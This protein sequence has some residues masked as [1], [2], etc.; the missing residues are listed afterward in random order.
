[1]N[2]VKTLLPEWF[3]VLLRPIYHWLLSCI[4]AFFY[5]RPSRKLV[6]IGVTGT[7]GKT[8]VVEFVSQILRSSGIKTAS[9]SSVY[10]RVGD[11]VQKNEFKM[12]MPGR[13]F[14]QKFLRRAMDEGATHAVLEITSE[15]VKQFRHKNIDWDILALTNITPEHIESH[16]SFENYRKA[17]EKVFAELSK[18]FRK[19][20]IPKMIIVNGDDPESQNFLKYD[21]DKKI[22]YSKKDAPQDTKLPGEFNLYNL[23][24]AIKVAEALGVDQEKIRQAVGKIE[25]VPGRMEFV[26]RETFSVVIDYAHT[27]DALRKVYETL[28]GANK[29]LICVL[30]SAGGG[31]DKWKRK[32]MGKIASEFC[33]QIIITNEDPYDEN[34]AGIIDEVALGAEESARVSPEK[35]A[36]T[37]ITKILDRK[38]A[39]NRAIQN[40]RPGDVVIIT[41]KGVEPWIM[42]PAGQKIPWDDREIARE[43][44]KQL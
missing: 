14:L 28:R 44:L 12:T 36:Q 8:S 24:A 22:I 25:G 39:I 17:K 27:P 37:S 19:P 29:K 38:E 10:F 30:G 1:M 40:A 31:R 21:A 2:L 26:Q 6:V 35:A 42:G 18:T 43:A 33:A 41:G 3:S 32:E 7:N 11:D 20:S 9:I 34:P 15:G 13:F 23:A 16:G 5:G 4:A